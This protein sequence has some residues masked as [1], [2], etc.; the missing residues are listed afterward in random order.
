LLTVAAPALA[1]ESALQRCRKIADPGQRLSC[2][3]AIVEPL[4]AAAPARSPAA[5]FGRPSRLAGDELEVIESSL[6]EDTD[7]WRA[8]T[9]FRLANGQVWQV[10]DDSTGWVRTGARKVR[11]RRGALGAFFLEIEGTNRSPKVR[12]VQ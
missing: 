6:M 4:P 3:D 12:R 7:G 8:N 11:V 1:D 10:V 9:Q 5:D 2:Y